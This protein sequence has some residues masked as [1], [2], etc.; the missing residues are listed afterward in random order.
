MGLVASD[1]AD[2][3]K[4][5]LGFSTLATTSETVGMAKAI[6]DELTINGLVN[7]ASGT[8]TGIAPSSGG[9]LSNGAGSGG[10]ISGLT[11]ASLA[12]RMKT[13]MGKPSISSPLLQMATSIANHLLTGIVSF[14]STKITGICTNTSSNPGPLT[15]GAGTDGVISG[16]SGT[17]LANDMK[18]GF[19]GTVS[20]EL[21]AMCNAIVNYIMTNGVVAYLSGSVTATCSAGG[22]PITLGTGVGGKIS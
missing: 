1:L 5:A 3:I 18:S 16:L 15:N 10:V 13:E 4:N 7:N 22:G 21:L 2:A 20:P 8:I 12:N 11:G 9:P 19:G 6:I 14:A 17:V